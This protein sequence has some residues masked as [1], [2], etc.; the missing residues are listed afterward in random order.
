M[1]TAHPP[2]TIWFSRIC[3]GILVAA[4]SLELAVASQAEKKPDSARAMFRALGVDDGYFDRLADGKP[5]DPSENETLLRV[6]FRLRTFPAVDLER[7]ALDADQLNA[8]IEQPAKLRGSIF[9]LRGRVTDVEPIKPPKEAADRYELPECFRC[10]LQLDAPPRTADIYTANVPAEW[11]K[12]AKPN[13]AAGAFGVFLKLGEKT[14]NRTPLIFAAPRLAWYPDNLLGQL[15][16]DV[17]LLDSVENQKPI[18]PADREA[19]YQMLAAVG[20]AK[21]GQLL[22]QA[23]KNLPKIP[24]NW[25]WTNRQDQEQYSVV[26]LF[27]EPA[28]QHGRLVALRGA[29]R[30]VEKIPVDEPDIVARFGI[31]HYYQIS[32]FTDDSQGNPL[33]F[34]IR[35]LPQGMPYGNL[36]RYGETVRIAG[37]FF[38]TWSYAVPKM[39]DPAITP[40]DPKTHRQL[41]PLLIGRSLSWYPVA[42]PAD[43]TP[44]NVAIGGLLALVMVIIWFVAWRSR[45]REGKWLAQMEAPPKLDA[46]VELDQLGQRADSGPDFSHVAEMDHGKKRD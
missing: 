26:P 46:G 8:V 3:C 33:T 5:I 32:L 45:R 20:R 12:G 28:T 18:T 1:A 37:F 34:C 35:E 36:P 30:R 44:S 22:R 40:G 15:G 11:R 23:E 41:S 16:M 4:V 29:A 42:K 21:P 14:D 25:R 6:L 17:G 39:A 7:W 9:R 10:R 31:N 43:N 19:F 24:E 2:S 13:A 38:K 27:N